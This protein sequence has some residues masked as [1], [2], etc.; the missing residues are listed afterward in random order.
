M[1]FQ[2]GYREVIFINTDSVLPRDCTN[3]C[4]QPCQTFFYQIFGFCQ[5]D[6]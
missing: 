3:A 6:R 4:T 1:Y 5:S 2:D